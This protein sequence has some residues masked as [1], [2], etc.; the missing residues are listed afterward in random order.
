MIISVVLLQGCAGFGYIYRM[1]IGVANFTNDS[2]WIYTRPHIRTHGHNHLLLRQRDSVW[3]YVWESASTGTY[4]TVIRHDLPVF[5]KDSLTKGTGI[6]I[7]RPHSAMYLDDIN[8]I[9]IVAP[10]DTIRLSSKEDVFQQ[11]IP[12]TRY[13]KAKNKQQ[14]FILLRYKRLIIV[15][16]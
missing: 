2:I 13:P 16:E 15:K 12:S 10:S 6:Y 14:R 9:N 1:D 4:S 3:T 7:L 11:S 5:Q 8:K